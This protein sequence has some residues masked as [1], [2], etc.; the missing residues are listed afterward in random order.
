MLENTIRKLAKQIDQQ[1]IF[2]ASKELPSLK[3]FENDNNLNK[4]QHIYLSYLFFYYNL[5]MDVSLKKVSDT[6]FNNE[7]DEDAYYYYKQNKSTES[8]DKDD[9]NKDIHL[10]FPKSKRGK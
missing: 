3:I 5:N 10:V 4:L 2:A 8:I 9:K 7:I 1:N 6:I